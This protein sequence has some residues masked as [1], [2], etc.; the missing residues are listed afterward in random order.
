MGILAYPSRMDPKHRNWFIQ[1]V[2]ILQVGYTGSVHY[3][4]LNAL[5]C[6]LFDV[7]VSAK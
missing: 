5:N 1:K 7:R 6:I 2:P 3:F 4:V